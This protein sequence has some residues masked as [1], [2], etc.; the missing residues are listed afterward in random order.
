MIIIFFGPPGAGKG[1]QASLVSKRLK[2]PHLSTGDILRNKLSD[3]DPLAIKFKKI[4]DAGNL[5]SDD[6]LNQIITNRI[7]DEDCKN[8]FI[9]DGYPRTILQKDYL[10][11]FLEKNDLIISKVFELSVS[12]DTIFNRIKSRS[13]IENRVD[14]R[15]EIIKNRIL[16]YSEETKPLSDYF[17]SKYSNNYHLIDG[18]RD[19]QKIQEDIMKFSQ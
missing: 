13:K 4:M 17:R 19:I 6:I 14:D 16:R 12:G 8:G 9:L 7:I 1:T 10:I 15:D 3:Q 2:V 11:S 5:V 18:N